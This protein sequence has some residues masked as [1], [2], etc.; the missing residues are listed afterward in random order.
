MFTLINNQRKQK[1]RTHVIAIAVTA[2]SLLS[3][4]SAQ[5]QEPSPANSDS[6]SRTN[7][8]ADTIP[9]G[10]D[11]TANVKVDTSRF[12][13]E[14][15]L[16][17]PRKAAFYSAVLPGLGQA[18]ND[19][20]WKVP[21]VYLG[22]GA[23]GYFVNVNHQRYSVLR[24]AYLEKELNGEDILDN[25]T[26]GRSFDAQY[27]QDRAERARRDR[28]YMIII[29]SFFYMFQIIDA[30]VDAHLREFDINEELAIRTRFIPEVQ[31]VGG[32]RMAG[33]T[34]QIQFGN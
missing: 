5:S 2:V 7:T 8:V 26:G 14:D 28:D 10:A 17:S 11:T 6:I 20:Y 22:F 25:E 31:N 34:L 18:Y 23:L 12:T 27:L 1:N 21:L 29:T 3:F 15:S 16:H 33:L 19:K 30:H 13:S 9:A 24:R 4:F 32:R